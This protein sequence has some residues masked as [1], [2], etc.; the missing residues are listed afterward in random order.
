MHYYNDHDKKC[1]QWIEKLIERGL[2][3]EGKVDCRSI[4]EVKPED[5]DGYEQAHMFSGISGWPLAIRSAGL[6]GRV[7]SGSCPCQPFSNSGRKQGF[8]DERHL[9]PEFFRLIDA[10]KPPVVVGEQA[11]S[12]LG[13]DWLAAVRTQMEA[14]GYAFWAVDLSAAIV[15]APHIRQRLYWGA[16]SW[17]TPI[18]SDCRGSSGRMD[19]KKQEQLSDQVRFTGWPTPTALSFNES[20]QPG[21]NRFTNTVKE[22]AGWATP[23]ARDHK[24][25]VCSKEFAAERDAHPRGKP[26]SYQV[27]GAK[28]TGSSAETASTGQLHP[29]FV[30]WLQGYPREWDV[31][32]D[33]ETQ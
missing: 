14:V 20:H 27:T 15:G 21:N 1:C 22:L 2:L 12:K 17:K 10:C 13:R 32:G 30:C 11:S 29:E 23:I 28:L 4:T 8:S 33:S 6:G 7:W 26:L 5:L 19:G 16:V 3:P 31:L 9:W 24:S 25:E 18:A